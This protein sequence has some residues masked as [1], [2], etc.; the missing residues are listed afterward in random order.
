[1]PRPFRR[2]LLAAG[3]L[4]LLSGANGADW[5]SGLAVRDLAGAPVP[6]TGRWI[7]LVFLSPE[8][9]VANAEVPVLNALA[10]EFAPHGF[11]FVGAYADPALEL[12]AL[13][14]HAAEYHL[15]FATA[16][17]RAQHLVHATG[18]H[19][20]PEAFVFSPDGTLLYRGRIDDRVGD[21]GPARP[22]AAQEDLREVLTA[23]A[24]GQPGPFKN[25]PGFGCSIPEPLK[26]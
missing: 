20:T 13:R 21:F 12:P 24:A 4:G 3:L 9:P 18:A 7:V 11:A 25:R 26:R 15:G 19:Y 23:L 8:C 22:V 5:W 10:A 2:L 6:A 16:D 17:D 1:M 14:R